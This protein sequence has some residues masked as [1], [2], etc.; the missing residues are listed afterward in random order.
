[1]EENADNGTGL[2]LGELREI[3]L[4]IPGEHFFCEAIP[5]PDGTNNEELEGLASLALEDKAFS[6]YPIEQLAWGFFGSVELGRIMV[7]A[8]PFAKLRNLGWQNLEYFRRV[9]PSFVSLLVARFDK[10]TVRFLLSEETLTA[11]AYQKDCTVP[12]SIFSLPAD[13]GNPESVEEARAKLLSLLDLEKFEIEPDILVLEEFSRTK[14]GFFKFEH[15]WLEGSHAS[16]ELEQDVMLAADELWK[17]DLRPPLFKG[18]EQKRRR[19][20]RFKWNAMISWG[21]G[22][23]AVLLMLAGVNYLR[24]VA[25]DKAL[26]SKVMFSEVPKVREDQKLLEKLRQNKLGGI[27]VFGALGRLAEH[28]GV[29]LDGPD[30]WFSEAHFE[31]RNE[32]RLEG[33]GKNVEAINN[34]IE[35]LELKKVA[36]ISKNRSGDEIR[37]IESD[38]GKTTFKIEFELMEDNNEK[39]KDE[40]SVVEEVQEKG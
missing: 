22:M 17:V 24:V 33:Q 3:T 19:L 23:A 5:L 37:E 1:M 32:V 34:F 35:K 4:L 16:L 7:F 21:L 2:H 20:S 6:P 36:F 18:T 13:Q 8:T 39:V 30:L 27:D 10:A 38:G 11:A 25:K 26:Q 12:E 15:R 31:S 14:D 9:F 29:G 28:R 40:E